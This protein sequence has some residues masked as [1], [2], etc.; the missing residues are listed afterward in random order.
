MFLHRGL[1]QPSVGSL[2][3]FLLP[4]A[5]ATLTAPLPRCPHEPRSQGSLLSWLSQH[6]LTQIPPPTQT[7][8]VPAY[9]WA[10]PNDYPVLSCATLHQ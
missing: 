4:H 8:K 10:A 2:S 7:P 5:P 1:R 9:P 3:S 6:L